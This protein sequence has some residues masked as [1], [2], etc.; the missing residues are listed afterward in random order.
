MASPDGRER[1]GDAERESTAEPDLGR[2]GVL[3]LFNLYTKMING[4]GIA[5]RTASAIA[6]A[7]AFRD[8]G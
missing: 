4:R 6:E 2:R 8:D 5:K 3:P 7:E 1:G